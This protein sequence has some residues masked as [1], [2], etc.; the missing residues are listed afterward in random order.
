MEE[1]I[2]YAKDKGYCYDNRH[3]FSELRKILLKSKNPPITK[4]IKTL[5]LHK[6]VEEMNRLMGEE[7]IRTQKLEIPYIGTLRSYERERYYDVETNKTTLPIMWGKTRQMK[8]D[9]ELGKGEKIFNANAMRIVKF[10]FSHK[11]KNYSPIWQFKICHDLAIKFIRYITDNNIP[12]IKDYK[13]EKDG[14]GD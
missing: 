7:Y 1:T 9:K 6:I 10:R 4:D 3:L 11:R 5:E 8:R 13:Y 14:K 12:M 2:K